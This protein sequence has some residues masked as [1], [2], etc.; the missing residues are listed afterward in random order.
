MT[1]S[2]S[3][4]VEI[5]A[6]EIG[7]I[8]EKHDLAETAPV[9]G[10]AR[11][12]AGRRFQPLARLRALGAGITAV[13]VKELRGRMRGRRAF[14]ILTLYLLFLAGFAWAWELIAERAYGTPA[15][16]MEAPRRSRPLSSARRSSGRC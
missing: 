10:T 5:P 1:D 16:S 3:R 11:G 14:V 2:T 7:D 6:A 8:Q 12:R 15:P 9:T 4:I 13:G